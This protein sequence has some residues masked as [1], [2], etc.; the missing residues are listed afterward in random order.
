MTKVHH[1]KTPLRYGENPHQQA[2]LE[3]NADTAFEQLHGKELSYNNLVDVDAVLQLIS[4]F[5]TS[6][7]KVFA[8]IKEKKR[9][10]VNKT[11]TL[12]TV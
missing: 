9:L 4:E 6:A 12:Q 3:G 7:D 11:G 1:K 5:H 8:I 10:A 2:F